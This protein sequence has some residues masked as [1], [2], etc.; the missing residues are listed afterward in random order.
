VTAAAVAWIR[1]QAGVI[2]MPRMLPSCAISPQQ[3]GRALD[4]IVST[5]AAAGIAVHKTT[6]ARMSNATF[7]PQCMNVVSRFQPKVST[8]ALSMRVSRVTFPEI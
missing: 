3:E 6:A 1:Q 4:R 7:L 5:Q 8:R 2:F